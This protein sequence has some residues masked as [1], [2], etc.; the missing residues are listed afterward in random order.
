MVPVGTALGPPWFSGWGGYGPRWA[1]LQARVPHPSPWLPALPLQSP[2]ALNCQSGPHRATPP[3]QS[4]GREAD[5]SATAHISQQRLGGGTGC[6]E[7]CQYRSKS[8][9]HRQ[10]HWPTLDRHA[11]LSPPCEV[12][13]TFRSCC[14]IAECRAQT[15]GGNCTHF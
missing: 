15:W 3:P 1:A 6:R 9:P 4:Q 5:Q 12:L 8:I 13:A 10:L 14:L 7:R 11:S 2:S